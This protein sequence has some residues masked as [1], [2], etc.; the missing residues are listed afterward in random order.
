M[1]KYCEKCGNRIRMG[2]VYC[3]QCGTVIPEPIT[4]DIPFIPNI[5]QLRHVTL[6]PGVTGAHRATYDKHTET[7]ESQD[8]KKVHVSCKALCIEVQSADT[9]NGNIHI[10]WD[11][12]DSWGVDAHINGD[13][14]RLHEHNYVGIKNISD[15][16]IQQ[17][18]R[19]L[20]IELPRGYQGDLIIENEAGSITVT[21]IDT[22]GLIEIKTTVGAVKVMN[23]NTKGDIYLSTHG[24]TMDI[25]NAEA[26]QIIRLSSLTR[27]LCAENV[28]A[29]VGISAT[30][31]NGRCMLRGIESA[32]YLTV[33]G[34]VGKVTLDDAR[35]AKIDIS[36]TAGGSVS[37]NNIY[38]DSAITIN[39]SSGPVTCA[40]DDDAENYTV[41][42]HSI[43]GKC[44]LADKSGNGSK[45]FR[46][47]TG[48]GDINV[49]FRND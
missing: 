33:N 38:A 43:R 48:L 37:C 40:I 15:Y 23:L 17:Q 31:T 28:K 7:Y 16:F 42:C 35:S 32:D 6:F 20:Q 26:T 22:E 10:S 24:G 49:Y 29:G 36:I 44:N 1:N 9:D 13:C 3:S 18:N 5:P 19:D 41:H 14:L 39:G 2:A 12:T 47:N 27:G 8:I 11:D 30:G 4:V 21:G 46:A 34:S 45:V 25:T